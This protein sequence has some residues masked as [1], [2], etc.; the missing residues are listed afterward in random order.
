MG[1]NKTQ[2]DV[3]YAKRYIRRVTIPFNDNNPEDQQMI[4]WL[5]KHI[6]KTAYIKELIVRDMIEKGEW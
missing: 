4:A 6:N 5:D 1:F 3:E 2:Y